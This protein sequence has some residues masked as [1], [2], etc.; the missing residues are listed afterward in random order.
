M[1]WL[2]TYSSTYD[3]ISP[4]KICCSRKRFE[5]SLPIKPATKSDSGV[6]KNTTSAI[7]QSV[8]SM[9]ISVPTIVTTPDKSCKNI[10]VRPSPT[11]STSF[12]TR[13][14]RSP[15]PWVSMYESG[16][17]LSFRNTSRR[18]SR[19]VRKLTRFTNQKVL[20]S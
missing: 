10:W 16:T 5:V 8:I 18:R 11:A 7:R 13:L 2:P 9:K 4:C 14:I 6:R 17:E 15:W 12:M 20:K 3:E 1:R 19:T